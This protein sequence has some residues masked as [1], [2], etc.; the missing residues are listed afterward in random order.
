MHSIENCPHNRTTRQYL[1]IVYDIRKNQRLN[2]REALCMKL[3]SILALLL[4]S[5]KT[6]D[7]VISGRDSNELAAWDFKPTTSAIL[8]VRDFH[9]LLTWFGPPAL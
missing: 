1:E 7:I 6:I 9:D 5:Q 8:S 3:L 2:S 4:R